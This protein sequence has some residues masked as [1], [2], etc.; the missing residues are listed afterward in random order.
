MIEG[1]HLEGGLSPSLPR[2]EVMQFVLFALFL[3]KIQTYKDNITSTVNIDNPSDNRLQNSQQIS[4]TE[5]MSKDPSNINTDNE[6]TMKIMGIS[7]K[8]NEEFYLNL[9]IDEWIKHFTELKDI[10]EG[11]W[12]EENYITVTEL[13]DTTESST[14]AYLGNGI[15]YE[16]SFSD[17]NEYNKLLDISFTFDN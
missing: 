8:A 7:Q 15:T 12:E 11:N 16:I 13:T 14:Y 6:I 2:A 10:G 5:A 3:N 4:F 1:R 17:R 9:I